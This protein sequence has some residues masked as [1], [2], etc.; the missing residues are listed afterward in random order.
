L[1]ADIV[2]IAPRLHQLNTVRSRGLGCPITRQ[3]CAG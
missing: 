1:S 2:A 3:I